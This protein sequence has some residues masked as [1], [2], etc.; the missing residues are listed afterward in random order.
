MSFAYVVDTSAVALLALLLVVREILRR[1]RLKYEYRWETFAVRGGAGRQLLHIRQTE[2]ES[3]ERLTLG[4]RLAGFGR[5]KQL[6]RRTFGPRVVIRSRVAHTI[7]IVISWEGQAI[8][9]LTPAGFRL[10]PG[11]G[12]R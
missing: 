7:P 9:G 4:G 11:E 2:I 1:A 12:A 5:F 6:S 8:A 3:L 10:K